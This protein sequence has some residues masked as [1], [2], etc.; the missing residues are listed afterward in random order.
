MSHLFHQG[1]ERVIVRT[2]NRFPQLD[3]PKRPD[4]LSY[5]APV[6][7]QDISSFQRLPLSMGFAKGFA[8]YQEATLNK[9]TATE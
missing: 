2:P 9:G 1:I 4:A 8:S 6:Q 3:S 7:K 5:S